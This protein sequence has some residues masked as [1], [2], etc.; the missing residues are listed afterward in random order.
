MHRLFTARPL[1]GN[2]VAQSGRT[3]PRHGL[4]SAFD[5]DISIGPDLCRSAHR[6]GGWVSG[7]DVD[8]FWYFQYPRLLSRRGAHTRRRA[9]LSHISCRRARGVTE[10][11]HRTFHGTWCVVPDVGCCRNGRREIRSR[12]VCELGT[13]LGRVRKSFRRA[14]HYGGVLRHDHDGFVQ[15]ARPDVGLAKR[16]HQMVMTT[17]AEGSTLQLREVRKSFPDP[18]DPVNRRLVLPGIS[19]TLAAVELVSIIG[20]SGCGKST[21]LRLIAGLDFPDFGELLV[22][23]ETISGP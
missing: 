9:R 14:R 22:D 15:G 7:Y 3:N 21:L 5:G 18:G 6:P 17:D 12:L 4:D 8:C 20:P 11:F 19:I 23:E 2:A 1:L 10:Y 13:R 16:S